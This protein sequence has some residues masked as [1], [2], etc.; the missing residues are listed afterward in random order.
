VY[1]AFGADIVTVWFETNVPNPNVNPTGPYS[2][3]YED[4]EEQE[5]AQVKA[6]EFDDAVM[7]ETNPGEGQAGA[8]AMVII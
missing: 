6:T 4:A 7:L 2:K 3:S 1:E 8:G 5:V